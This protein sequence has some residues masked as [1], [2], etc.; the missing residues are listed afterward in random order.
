[1]HNDG[2]HPGSEQHSI[3]DVALELASLSDSPGHDGGSSCGKLHDPSQLPYKEAQKEP[4][5]HSRIM[6][7]QRNK[8]KKNDKVRGRERQ[9][10][11]CSSENGMGKTNL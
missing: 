7:A 10:R 5:A 6:Q 4:A 3:Q 11:A 2:V 1:V 9:H 8:N